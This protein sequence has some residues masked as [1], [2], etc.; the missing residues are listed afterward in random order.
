MESKD[1]FDAVSKN[2]QR[3]AYKMDNKWLI[4]NYFALK[5]R[6]YAPLT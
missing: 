1:E 6:I 2:M 3:S 5:F 4:I